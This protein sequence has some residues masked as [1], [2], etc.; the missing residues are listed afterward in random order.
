MEQNPVTPDES[1]SAASGPSKFSALPERTMPK[2][3]VQEVDVEQVHFSAP[4]TDDWLKKA[5]G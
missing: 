3:Y 2:D 5:G 4:T 1:A